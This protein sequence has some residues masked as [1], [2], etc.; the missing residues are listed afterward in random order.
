MTARAAGESSAHV[1][2]RCRSLS[3]PAGRPPDAGRR[4]SRA[5]RR[6]AAPGRGGWSSHRRRGRP[7]R[8]PPRC[9]PATLSSAATV[10]AGSTPS[11]SQAQPEA[12]RVGLAVD[13]VVGGHHDARPGRAGRARHRRAPDTQSGPADVTIATGTP[14]PGPRPGPGRWR[15]RTSPGGTSRRHLGALT[16]RAISSA[17]WPC[18][19]P[20][21]VGE[22]VL[23]PAPGEQRQVG[24]RPAAGLEVRAGSPSRWSGSE[25]TRV[26]SRSSSSA[27][28]ASPGASKSGSPA[29][30]VVPASGPAPSPRVG[31]SRRPGR[32]STSPPPDRRRVPVDDGVAGRE[33]RALLGDEL[34]AA[35]PRAGP[36]R[37]R[38]GRARRRR[39]R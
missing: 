12:G 2:A 22:H 20:S 13:D 28:T 31:P 18:Q 17:S 26:P 24:H 25:S 8:R 15:R 11:R 36:C 34:E 3:D 5:R 32:S 16:A 7:R 27:V 33:G 1:R 14:R 4:T 23:G 35:R 10:S 38:G 19:G 37:C 21:R 30:T 6:R 9:T 29:A 39:R